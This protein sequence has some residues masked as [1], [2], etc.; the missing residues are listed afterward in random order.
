MLEHWLIELVVHIS[1]LS[2]AQLVRRTVPAGEGL[3]ATAS[4]GLSGGSDPR[5]SS[6]A[7]NTLAFTCARTLSASSARQ[8]NVGNSLKGCE[9]ANRCSSAPDI[10]LGS[11]CP[12]V[13]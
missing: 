7:F 6:I 2:D 8:T 11:C 1:G 3:V 13:C 4:P 12:L 10:T 9:S 5:D